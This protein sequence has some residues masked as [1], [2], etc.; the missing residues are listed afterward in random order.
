M[1]EANGTL[2]VIGVGPGDP[3]LMTLKAARIIAACPVVAYPVTPSG[4]SMAREIA[5]AHICPDARELPFEVP[6]AVEREPARAAYDSAA[7][8]IDTHLTAG[9]DVALLCAGDPF[10]FGSA[11][12][13]FD[14]LTANHPTAVVPGV[15]SLTACAAAAK[16]PLAARNDVLKV[17]P[18]TMDGDDL[19]R[20]LASGD[21]FALIKVGRHFAK[22]RKILTEMQL[23][24]RAWLVGSASGNTQTVQTLEGLAE[25][26]KPYFTTILIYRGPEPWG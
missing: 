2:H 1:P 3:E 16:R 5:A 21:S 7:Q 18:A 24:D 22:L 26:A 9:R 8:Q 20:E 12:Y 11:M 14:R 13:V 4:R 23:A 15:T 10:L 19:R 17:L 25:D 6:M